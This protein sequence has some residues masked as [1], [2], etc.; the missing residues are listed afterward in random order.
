MAAIGWWG[1]CWWSQ[2]LTLI[3]MMEFP[4]RVIIITMED[5]ADG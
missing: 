4:T 2:V 3:G 1:L 5:A